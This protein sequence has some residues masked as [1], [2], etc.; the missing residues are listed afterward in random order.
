MSRYP[1][2]KVRVLDVDGNNVSI[3][4]IIIGA[5]GVGPSLI[6]NRKLT[7]SVWTV[8]HRKSGLVIAF[9]TDLQVSINFAHYLEREYGDLEGFAKR[10]MSNS[11]TDSDALM[12][13]TLR[14]RRKHVTWI[15]ETKNASGNHGW[16]YHKPLV[17]FNLSQ[18]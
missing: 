7:S 13:I 14:D 4:R 10:V 3:Y 9:Y 1:W 16:E 11:M 17:R 2:T 8:D 15:E 12:R 18:Y 5:Y 6:E